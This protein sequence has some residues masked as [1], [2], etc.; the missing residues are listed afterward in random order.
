M[1][2]RLEIDHLTGLYSRKK[3]NDDI[4]VLI[5]RKMK[6]AVCYIDFV[7][8]KKLNDTKGHD[9]GDHVL[10]KF[11]EYMLSLPCEYQTYRVG[12]D[13]FIVIIK[14]SSEETINNDLLQILEIYKSTEPNLDYSFNIG[15]SFYPSQETNKDKLIKRADTAMYRAKERN[16]D[17]FISK[18]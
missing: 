14:G 1:K 4:D 7:G 6:F 13:E 3:L 17:Y 10:K 8:F 16:I 5:F 2:S 9:H 12:G 15:I 18:K 11:A